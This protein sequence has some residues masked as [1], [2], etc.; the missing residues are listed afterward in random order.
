MGKLLF[1]KRDFE[2]RDARHLSNAAYSV[3]PFLLSVG[4]LLNSCLLWKMY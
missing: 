2:A 3:A 1:L 4:L